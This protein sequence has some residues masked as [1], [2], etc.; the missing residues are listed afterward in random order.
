MLGLSWAGSVAVMVV[1]ASGVVIV[2]P[3][4]LGFFLGAL[5]GTINAGV[6]G[7]E[8]AWEEIE[9]FEKASFGREVPCRFD[10]DVFT[11][12]FFMLRIFLFGDSARSTPGR[13]GNELE[14]WSFRS[15]SSIV[16]P[17]TGLVLRL[18]KVAKGK[19]DSGDSGGEFGDGSVSEDSMVEMVVVGEDS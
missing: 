4:L 7:A 18:L 10:A 9:V 6:G 3:K 17:E 19:S 13:V 14:N 8:N 16:C 12:R 1:G 15:L 2:S 5:G 11:D